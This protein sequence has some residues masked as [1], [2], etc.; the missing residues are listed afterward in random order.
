MDMESMF[1]FLQLFLNDEP[2]RGEN[3]GTD[4]FHNGSAYIFVDTCLT[5]DTGRYETAIQINGG[6]IVIVEDY[7]DRYDAKMGHKR[8]VNTG[9][10]NKFSFHSIQTGEMYIYEVEE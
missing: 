6:E 4:R 5:N 8:W 1:N 10:Q 2:I 3:I 7:E 9:K